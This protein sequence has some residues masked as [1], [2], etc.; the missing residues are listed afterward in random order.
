MSERIIV[1][2]T[3]YHKRINNIPVVLD[4]IFSQ[5][6]PPD[7]VVMNLAFDEIVPEI[8]QRY[9]DEH[10][11]EIQRV[12]DTKVYK[13]LIPT[14]KKYPEDCI[15]TIDDDLLYPSGMIEDFISVHKQ[16]PGFPI[17]GNQEVYYGM[18][19]H[20][21]CASLIKA[22]YLGADI[23]LIDD[24]TIKH[25]PCD[26]IVYTYFSNKNLH[27]YLRT[28][29]LYYLNLPSYNPV[30]SYSDNEVGRRGLFNTYNYLVNRWGELPLNF[31]QYNEEY[32]DLIMRDILKS[33]KNLGREENQSTISYRLGDFLLR[34]LKRIRDKFQRHPESAN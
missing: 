4:T 19:C 5:S 32:R 27:P 9:I 12:P 30:G 24:D 13:K 18:Q 14:L 31:F 16:Y 26:D 7:L 11:I 17:S 15:V 6:L 21:G 20:C 22:E 29:G 10:S 8:V 23:D 25:C 1:T 33:Y 28:K 2:L 34:P 3:T